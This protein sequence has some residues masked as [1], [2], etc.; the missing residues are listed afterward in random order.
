[1]L[2]DTVKPAFYDEMLARV[3]SVVDPSTIGYVISNHSELDHSGC[4]PRVAAELAPQ[5]IIASRQG[6]KALADHFHWGREVRVVAEGEELELGTARFSFVETRMLHWPDSMFTYLHGDR[7]LFSNDAFGMHL[8]TAERFVDELDW[9]MVRWEAAKYYAN[10]LLPPSSLVQKLLERFPRLGLDVAC[11][12]P[13]HGP[14]WREDPGRILG[15]YGEWA[16]PGPQSRAVVAYDTMWQ[17]TALM[18]RAAGEGLIAAG[19]SPVL[20]PLGESHRSDVATEL[21]EAGGLLV[22]SP[23]M[24][25]QIYPT[26]ADLLTYL[27]GLKPRGLVGA[28]F[29]SY[30]W[31]GEA[32][33]QL[34]QRLEEMKVELVG[35]G[36]RVRYVPDGEALSRCQELG[37]QVGERIVARLASD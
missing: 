21:L 12:A 3:A 16:T 31:S 13:D 4:L 28:A 8:A 9:S 2:I 29:G 22:G 33:A 5:Q 17:S 7:V 25:N 11:L 1:V 10:I 36:V 32:L 6:E 19:A 14:I 30:G 15:L 26:C 23:T 35:D 24:N 20:M 34:Q 27:Q 37:R 18:A